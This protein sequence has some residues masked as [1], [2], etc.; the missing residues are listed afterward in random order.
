MHASRNEP[1]QCKACNKANFSSAGDLVQHYEG[2]QC[3]RISAAKFQSFR[4]HKKHIEDLLKKEVA[5]DTNW[6]V[7][8]SLNITTAS[9]H[10]VKRPDTGLQSMHDHGAGRGGWSVDLLGDSLKD[11]CTL[12]TSMPAAM[13]SSTRQ[14]KRMSPTSLEEFRHLTVGA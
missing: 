6:M 2:G 1:L 13:Q 9:K 10:M 5:S 7:E 14:D 12:A 11:N 8:V 3:A 4:L